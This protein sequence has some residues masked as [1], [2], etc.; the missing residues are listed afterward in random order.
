MT[1]ALAS[2]PLGPVSPSLLD[3][4]TCPLR[5][6]FSQSVSRAGRQ[7]PH[8]QTATALLG[9]IAHDTIEATLH[10]EEFDHAWTAAVES[11]RTDDFPSPDALPTARRTHLRIRKRLPALL[12]LLSGLGPNLELLTEYDLKTVDGALSGRPDLIAHGSE[13]LVIDYKSGLVKLDSEIRETYERQLLLY[14]ALV[15]ECLGFIA[16]RL[17]LFSLRQGIIEIPADR[18]VMQETAKQA[19]QIRLDFN[20][21]TPGPQPGH[22]SPTTCRF[23]PHAPVCDPFWEA[24]DETWAPEV[25]LAVRGQLLTVPENS[26]WG[27]S[28]V[29]VKADGGPLRGREVHINAIARDLISNA[30]EGDRFAAVDL[31]PLADDPSLLGCSPDPVDQRVAIS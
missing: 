5:I 8:R 11:H 20:R 18:H 27:Q 3:K 2:R 15:R 23:C 25:G 22:P 1:G 21:R 31:R 10:G 12:G 6:A 24:V 29:I 4:L 26:A 30:S 17:L 14:G 13:T 7:R 28:T 16:K 19:R 9:D